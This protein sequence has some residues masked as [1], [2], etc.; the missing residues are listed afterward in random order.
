MDDDQQPLEGDE[1][2]KE[3]ALTGANPVGDVNDDTASGE[4]SDAV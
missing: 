1:S 4:E 3:E 2:E